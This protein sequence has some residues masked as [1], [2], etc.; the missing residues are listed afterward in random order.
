[1]LQ[2]GKAG[3]EEEEEEEE[4]VGRNVATYR[5]LARGALYQVPK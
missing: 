5:P 4:G 3:I 2:L 1:M